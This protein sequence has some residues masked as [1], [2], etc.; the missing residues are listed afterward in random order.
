MASTSSLFPSLLSGEGVD[1][2]VKV[3]DST[4]FGTFR[5]ELQ[6]KNLSSWKN[7]ENCFSQLSISLVH[8]QYTP[9]YILN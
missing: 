6:V 5:P 9:N 2:T 4:P 1:V 3:P 8:I 7:S